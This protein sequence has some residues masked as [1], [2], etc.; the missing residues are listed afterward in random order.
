MSSVESYRKPANIWDLKPR[1]KR[2]DRADSSASS[3]KLPR[4]SSGSRLK[5]IAG[6]WLV[7]K[8]EEESLNNAPESS[9]TAPTAQTSPRRRSELPISP[10][11]KEPVTRAAKRKP[12]SNLQTESPKRVVTGMDSPGSV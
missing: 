9:R 11:R 12:S 7:E 2:E 5:D 3:D 1:R 10:T 8:E 6:T 4:D